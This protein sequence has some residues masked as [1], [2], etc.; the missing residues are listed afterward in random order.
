VILGPF[1]YTGSRRLE[2]PPAES[3]GMCFTGL[4][5]KQSEISVSCDSMG[6]RVY[7]LIYGRVARS[8]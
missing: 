7:Q 3:G 6:T 2:L 4:R 8:F 5:R 1:F